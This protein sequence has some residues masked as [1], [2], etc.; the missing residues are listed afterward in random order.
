MSEGKVMTAAIAAQIVRG[1]DYEA[2]MRAISRGLEPPAE[3]H[4]DDYDTLGEGAA[5]E[6]VK[7]DGGI[8]INAVQSI[9]RADAEVFSG[10]NGDLALGL[11]EL[12]TEVAA[13]L[14]RHSGIRLSFTKLMSL[15]VG[16]ATELAQHSTWLCFD[17]L[18]TIDEA[19]AAALATHLGKLQMPQLSE[20][21]ES[22]RAVLSH[23]LGELRI[24]APPEAQ[25][26]T[27]AAPDAGYDGPELL[28]QLADG[29]CNAVVLIHASA[30]AVCAELAQVEGCVGV[31]AQLGDGPW[32]WLELSYGDGEGYEL[33]CA[34]VAVASGNVP[35]GKL[36]YEDAIYTAAFMSERLETSA[37][38]I[39][40]S[41]QGEAI[42]GLALLERGGV[43]R[44]MTSAPPD[45]LKALADA[46]ADEDS[47]LDSVLE[48]LSHNTHW[49]WPEQKAA[50][51][52]IDD[53][54]DAW[55]H[56]QGFDLSLLSEPLDAIQGVDG[57]GKLI[58]FGSR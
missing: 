3:P 34:S 6:L 30:E 27:Q 7:D 17:R 32:A 24:P 53:F 20:I 33:L 15:S 18:R 56:E 37:I 12:P 50:P 55:L 44:A 43:S 45:F 29:S 23:H 36:C 39:W 25:P 16:A 57:I 19:T 8:Y 10:Y 26:E 9:S 48:Q 54:G 22:V 14:A 51:G 52:R 49:V 21:S 35:E 5:A 1:T 28:G 31:V 2:M 4:P 41:D 46:H 38:A 58:R 11:T 13:M 42:A 40:G 47:D